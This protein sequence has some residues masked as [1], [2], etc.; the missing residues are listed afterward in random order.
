[1]AEGRGF[2]ELMNG[3]RSEYMRMEDAAQVV[4][5]RLAATH[6]AG[7]RMSSNRC[8]RVT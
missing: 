4:I 1:M 5:S 6:A 3:R 2:E 8:G 7:T